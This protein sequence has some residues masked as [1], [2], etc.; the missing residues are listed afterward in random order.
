MTN[1]DRDWR[2][3]PIVHVYTESDQVRIVGAVKGDLL[4]AIAMAMGKGTGQGG[5]LLTNLVRYPVIVER[6]DYENE[7][8]FLTLPAISPVPKAI[9][10][11]HK[12]RV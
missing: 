9:S 6:K 5:L 7:W 3:S 2:A 1:D 12:E 10:G 4:Y 11:I 8:Q